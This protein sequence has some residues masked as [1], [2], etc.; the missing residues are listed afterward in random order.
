MKKILSELRIPS[1]PTKNMYE[2]L[3]NTISERCL[4][5][6]TADNQKKTVIESVWLHVVSLYV[7][8]II[9][10]KTA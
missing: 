9:P 7:I 1:N 4:I 8:L 5:N 6:L 10:I 2:Y 3:P